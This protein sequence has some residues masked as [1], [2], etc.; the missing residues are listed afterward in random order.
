MAQGLL[1]FNA[2]SRSAGKAA[3]A[4]HR[5]A[6][7]SYGRGP[8]LSRASEEIRV[9]HERYYAF[10]PASDGQVKA[11]T[12]RNRPAPT[13]PSE[14]STTHRFR[15]I[16]I[17][18]GAEG[19]FLQQARPHGHATS[20]GTSN[21]RSDARMRQQQPSPMC[22]SFWENWTR[23]ADGWI[24]RSRS[25]TRWCRGFASTQFRFCSLFRAQRQ[26][27]SPHES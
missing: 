13:P 22:I 17:D 1:R 24:Q 27:R 9:D 3:C 25:R 21:P 8:A 23:P 20:S 18:P 11:S 14:L 15:R 26:K 4:T 6:A 5:F 12:R 10:G 19:T 2:A 16:A 7:R